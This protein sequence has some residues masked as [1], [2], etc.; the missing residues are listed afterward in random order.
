MKEVG[1]MGQRLF[2]F[3]SYLEAPVNSKL[4]TISF[5]AMLLWRGGN[6]AD[7]II[8]L[9]IIALTQ[10]IPFILK[11]ILQIFKLAG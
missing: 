2:S 11:F 4:R 9:R 3:R 6:D 5:R 7:Y 8:G 1:W 10:Y